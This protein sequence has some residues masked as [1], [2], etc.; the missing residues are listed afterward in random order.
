MNVNGEH[1]IVAQI[2]I[3]QDLEGQVLTECRGADKIHA[4]G[5]MA[6]SMISLATSKPKEES[7][8]VPASRILP[9]PEG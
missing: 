6:L 5:L 3:A 4:L 8:I 2:V 9:P 1:K 7:Q